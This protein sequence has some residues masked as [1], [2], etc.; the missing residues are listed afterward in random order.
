MKEVT[1]YKIFL[2]C[3]LQSFSFLYQQ[4][5]LLYSLLILFNTFLLMFFWYSYYYYC[6]QSQIL[7]KLFIVVFSTRLLI[8]YLNNHY[9]FL[10]F[11]LNYNIG[12]FMLNFFH[13]YHILHLFSIFI[14]LFFDFPKIFNLHYHQN[15]LN[16]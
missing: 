11:Y 6:Y 3:F 10:Y 15:F 13:H 8:S 14:V 7:I 16:E 1:Y 4:N 12:A 5:Y 9:Y 2:V